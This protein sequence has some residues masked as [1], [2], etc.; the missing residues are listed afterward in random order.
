MPYAI[1]VLTRGTE[2][3]S[4]YA[5]RGTDAAY[6]VAVD[7]RDSRRPESALAAPA[8]VEFAVYAA[9]PPTNVSGTHVMHRGGASWYRPTR[10]LRAVRYKRGA[11]PHS[12]VLTYRMGL[13]AGWK[14]VSF[15]KEK[16][17]VS[18]HAFRTAMSGTQPM[19]ARRND[20]V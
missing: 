18:A 9:Y 4:P 1:A 20:P 15:T 11:W 10:A 6:G 19:R 3:I 16:K 14:S 8:A 2:G 7:V 12:L 17:K 5:L 13:Q